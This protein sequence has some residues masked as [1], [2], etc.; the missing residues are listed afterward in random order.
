MKKKFGIICLVFGLVFGLME[1]QY[2]GNNWT[3]QSKE[4]IMCDLASLLL[5]FAGF[6]LIKED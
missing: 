1:T 5:S 3:P 4:E 2:F 6:V